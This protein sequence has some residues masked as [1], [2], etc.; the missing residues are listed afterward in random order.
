MGLHVYTLPLPYERTLWPFLCYLS[1]AFHHC[2]QGLQRLVSRV[3]WV[4]SQC[5]ILQSSDS[6]LHL[7]CNTQET[8]IL[9]RHLN[10]YMPMKQFLH[11]FPTLVSIGKLHCGPNPYIMISF[12]IVLIID[13]FL[14]NMIYKLVLMELNPIWKINSW[15]FLQSLRR[16]KRQSPIMVSWKKI[17]FGFITA[18]MPGFF[19]PPPWNYI[20]IFLLYFCHFIAYSCYSQ[21]WKMQTCHAE[22][23]A[24]WLASFFLFLFFV[25]HE[26]LGNSNW[27]L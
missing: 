20:R 23:I 24:V 16:L 7:P 10:A 13:F 25:N 17:I 1:G 22:T 12:G 6:C 19:L 8:V 27:I 14:T 26:I 3:R 18:W 11:W 5:L 21:C 4:F 15:C 2:C 9:S